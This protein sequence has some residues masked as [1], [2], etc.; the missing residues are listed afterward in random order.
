MLAISF[1][2]FHALC[3]SGALFQ[4]RVRVAKNEGSACGCTVE[5]RFLL[6]QEK[7]S[8]SPSELLHDIERL[9]PLNDWV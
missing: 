1:A 6:L 7:C 3:F 2:V 8:P 9:S 5:M 4:H